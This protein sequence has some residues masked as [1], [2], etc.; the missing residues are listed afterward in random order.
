[1]KKNI[2]SHQKWTLLVIR[3]NDTQKTCK[4]ENVR[5]HKW[6]VY[7]EMLNNINLVKIKDMFKTTNICQR[8]VKKNNKTK[9]FFFNLLY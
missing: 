9:S 7:L 5:S 1:M 8:E 3:R 2:I 6:V 4:D